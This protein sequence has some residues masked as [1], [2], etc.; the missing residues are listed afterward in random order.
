MVQTEMEKSKPL[1]AIFGAGMM[2]SGIAQV[3]IQAGYP[4]NLYGRS[5]KKLLEARETIK[6][7]LIRV[8]GK[9]KV[10]IPMEP[11][12]LEQIALMQ[13]ELL[14]IHTDIPSAVE[15]ASMAIEAVAENL[16]LKLDIFQTIQKTCPEHCMLI[17]NTSSLKLSQ[18]LPVIKN[19]SLFAGLHFFNP[20]P[21]MKLVEVVSTDETSQDTTDFLFNF[22]KEIKKLPVAAKDTPGFIVNRLLIPYLMD[23]IRM[24]ERGDATKEDIDT[25]MRFG[26][27]YPMGPIELCDYVG[28]DVLQSTL[29]IFRETVPGDARFAPIQLL[30]KLVSEGKLGRKTKQGFY[31]Y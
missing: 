26:T 5:E 10:D 22:C 24:L 28:L 25:A 27:S 1:V 16:D 15:D 12:A 18:M 31:T 4:V 14:Q 8:A 7:N 19:P 29:K 6:K 21:V 17:T 30:D 3:C 23:S 2:G 20:V 9:K 13:L 11:E